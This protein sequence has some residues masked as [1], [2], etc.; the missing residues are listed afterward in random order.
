MYKIKTLS[1]VI[2][3]YNEKESILDTIRNIIN[4]VGPFIEDLEII[5]VDDNSSDAT[6]VILRKLAEQEKRLRVVTNRGKRG[7]GNALRAGFGHASKE[8]VL[9]TDADMPCD[10]EELKRAVNLMEEEQADVVSAYRLNNKQGGLKRYLYSRVFNFLMRALLHLRIRD[11]NFSF[12]LFKKNSWTPWACNQR[13]LL[14]MPNYSPRL[15]RRA[16]RLFSSRRYFCPGKRANPSWIISAI[17][18]R[19]SGS[20]LFFYANGGIPSQDLLTNERVKRRSFF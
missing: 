10:P 7:L 6:P 16:I 3:V 13:A 19:L 14:L 9:Y 15:L 11:I 17:S 4:R 2:P 8:A 5:A 20:Q 1:V 18:R 12:K